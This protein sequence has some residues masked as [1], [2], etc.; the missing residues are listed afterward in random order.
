M[1]GIAEDWKFRDDVSKTVTE[2]VE[3]NHDIKTVWRE[4]AQVLEG[5]ADAEHRRTRFAGE[6]DR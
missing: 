5:G 2:Y 6:Y 4:L 3:S 1:V